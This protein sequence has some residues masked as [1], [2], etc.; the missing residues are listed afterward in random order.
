MS[1]DSALSVRIV[2][3]IHAGLTI[4]VAL[5]LGRECGVLFGP[6]GAGKSSLL[7]LIAGLMRP[8]AGS[9]LVDGEIL[10]DASADQSAL[11]LAAGGIG[12]SG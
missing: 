12:I 1:D 9:V 8:D 11:A 2:R 5:E 4:D 6:S 3:K 10:F 7:K